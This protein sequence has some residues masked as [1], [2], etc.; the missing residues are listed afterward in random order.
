MIKSDGENQFN[1]QEFLIF[2]RNNDS[3]T[4]DIFFK[5]PTQS[6]TKFIS[7]AQLIIKK[8][9]EKMPHKK[10]IRKFIFNKIKNDLSFSCEF[11]ESL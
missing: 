1:Q 10:S 11:S 5:R 2:F 6:F 8:T 7:L 9:V 3:K 4:S